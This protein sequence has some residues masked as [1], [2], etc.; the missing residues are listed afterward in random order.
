MRKC[1]RIFTCPNCTWFRNLDETL[2]VEVFRH[3]IY[4]R[5]TGAQMAELDVK[6]HKCHTHNWR[7]GMLGHKVNPTPANTII[8]DLDEVVRFV[9]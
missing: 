5:V 3:P 1:G 4:G 8:I 9:G 2:A 6:N 7:R